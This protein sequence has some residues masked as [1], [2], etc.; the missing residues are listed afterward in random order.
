MK[1]TLFLCCL[2]LAFGCRKNKDTNNASTPLAN[3]SVYNYQSNFRTWPFS[4]ISNNDGNIVMLAVAQE[5]KPVNPAFKPSTD[6]FMYSQSGGFLSRHSIVVPD[7]AYYGPPR[8][9]SVAQTNSGD[10][11][12][13]GTSYKKVPFNSSFLI[14]S[15]IALMKTNSNGDV[16]WLKTLGG[17]KDDYGTLVKK[18]QDG[19]F[20]V[21]GTSTSFGKDI[22]SDIYMVKV[23]ADG[24]ILW[25]KNFESPEQQTIGGI[26]ETADGNIFLNVSDNY[27]TGHANLMWIMTDANG[28]L[29]WQ[30]QAVYGS[31]AHASSAALCKNG[32]IIL[33]YT[34]GV[35][36]VARIDNRANILWDNSNYAPPGETNFLQSAPCIQHNGDDTYTLAGNR[37]IDF[38]AYSQMYTFKINGNG[39]LLM[40]KNLAG[41]YSNVPFNLV[42]A[43]NGNNFITGLQMRDSTIAN[44]FL[45][46]ANDY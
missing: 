6:L 24:D 2:L 46:K 32:D 13:C 18:T 20:I 22:Y 34:N 43:A 39:S 35:L 44:V 41:D 36:H 45:I 42:K 7:T 12:L 5:T 30:K 4:T 27:G 16:L 21:A 40:F 3:D 9:Y 8:L 28:N 26:T 23:N 25:T 33:T 37:K 1:P 10:Y 38:D 14:G 19:N 15:D 29:L 31:N 17:N 11:L